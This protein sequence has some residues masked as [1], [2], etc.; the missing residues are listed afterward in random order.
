MTAA[1]DVADM[2]ES[3]KSAYA[4][5]C[6]PKGLLQQSGR[7][8]PQAQG[9]RLTALGMRPRR[10]AL[11]MGHPLIALD[12]G[13]CQEAL[14]ESPWGKAQALGHIQK[15]PGQ[16]STATAPEQGCTAT[17]PG[18]GCWASALMTGPLLF[19]YG[20]AVLEAR[21]QAASA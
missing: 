13:H 12:Y 14:R 18:Q 8:A 2:S 5:C 1:H 11:R 15:A 6:R 20:L 17:A 3:P 7:Q 19:L 4:Y 10:T 9:L 21:L 16:G